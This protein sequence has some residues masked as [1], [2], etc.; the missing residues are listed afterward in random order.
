MTH[1]LHSRSWLIREKVVTFSQAR[2]HGGEWPV[3]WGKRTETMKKDNRS[4]EQKWPR[5]SGKSARRLGDR[6]ASPFCE[7]YFDDTF[8]RLF[9]KII[10]KVSFVH[11]FVYQMIMQ[12]LLPN[13]ETLRL[14]LRKKLFH[15][16]ERL[17]CLSA[18][19][20]FFLY[21]RQTDTV[22]LLIDI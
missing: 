12:I 22:D 21:D 13:N 2:V 16:R 7:W 10:R 3:R 11:R 19:R 17:V 1:P 18:K 15:A 14:F 8:M 6:R 20:G 5:P 9:C 4:D